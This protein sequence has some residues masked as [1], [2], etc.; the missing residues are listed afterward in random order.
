MEKLLSSREKEKDVSLPPFFLLVGE[1]SPFFPPHRAPSQTTLG[2]SAADKGLEL[3]PLFSF[4]DAERPVFAL[5]LRV[6][7]KRSCNPC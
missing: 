6:S 7:R 4:F 5:P 1:S 2:D 3:F